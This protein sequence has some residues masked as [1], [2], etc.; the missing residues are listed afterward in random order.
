MTLKRVGLIFLALSLVLSLV[1]GCAP[2]QAAE[3][4][5]TPE[6]FAGKT[7]TIFCDTAV[8]GTTDMEAR[9]FSLHI[10]RYLPGNPTVIV[11]NVTGGAKLAVCNLFQNTAARDGT[12]IL[13]SSCSY[14][15]PELMELPA[16]DFDS[17]TWK[18][19]AGHGM[20]QVYVGRTG[21]PGVDKPTDIINAKELFVAASSSSSGGAM[22][23]L[24]VFETLGI[25]ITEAVFGLGGGSRR[26]ALLAGEADVNE[27]A[28]VRP[29]VDFEVFEMHFHKVGFKRK[30]GRQGKGCKQVF[31][32]HVEAAIDISCFVLAFFSEG[33]QPTALV[34]DNRS[35]SAQIVHVLYGDC[36]V[37]FPVAVSCQ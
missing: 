17:D 35:I 5:P 33:D 8:G 30:S 26:R 14:L 18:F 10:G 19:F 9:L 6:Y 7:V 36:H 37:R 15:V 2:K 23:G 3:P 4:T 24:V 31:F 27:I 22:T 25:P 29:N 16:V 21:I 12:A 34:E 20:S 1:V 13:V 28:F 32:D 11:R